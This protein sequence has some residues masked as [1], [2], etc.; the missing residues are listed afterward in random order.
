MLGGGAG[1]KQ[2]SPILKSQRKKIKS[3]VGVM[4]SLP[5]LTNQRNIDKSRIKTVRVTTPSWKKVRVDKSQMPRHLVS[6]SCKLTSDVVPDSPSSVFMKH[7]DSFLENIDFDEIDSICSSLESTPRRK[8]K[9][10]GTKKTLLNSIENSCGYN[11]RKTPQRTKSKGDFSVNLPVTK[12]KEGNDGDSE[13]CES[14][15]DQVFDIYE[16]FQPSKQTWEKG[17]P[18]KVNQDFCVVSESSYSSS[19]SG[20]TQNIPSSDSKYDSNT[21]QKRVLSSPQ[22]FHGRDSPDIFDEEPFGLSNDRLSDSFDAEL[23]LIEKGYSKKCVDDFGKA[24]IKT[25][26]NFDNLSRVALLGNAYSDEPVI[27]SSDS[28][29]SFTSTLDSQP[30][31]G[32]FQHKLKE[33]ATS[34]PS[35][36]C[37]LYLVCVKFF[38]IA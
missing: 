27:K 23:C 7:D 15:E 31:I 21:E 37:S 6:P 33:L 20:I 24:K 10:V 32:R 14:G 19:S 13:N 16:E 26:Q 9:T 4:Q 3:Q 22:Q 2:S 17:I 8:V 25:K 11:L 29:I 35:G 5:I 18:R 36:G 1:V 38:S 12:R 30:L 34:Q 28:Q